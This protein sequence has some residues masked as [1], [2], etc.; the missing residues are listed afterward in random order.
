MKYTTTKNIPMVSIQKNNYTDIGLETLLSPLGGIK[1]YINRGERVLLKTNLLSPS[2]PEKAVVTH[3]AVVH[4]AAQAILK[5]G[6]SSP[7]EDWRNLIR[8]QD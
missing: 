5:I 4:A 7:K 3:P 2:E 6:D 1:K 8:N